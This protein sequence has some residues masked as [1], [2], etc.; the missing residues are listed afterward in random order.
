MKFE[1]IEGIKDDWE[2][3]LKTIIKIITDKYLPGEEYT[4]KP[5]IKEKQEIIEKVVEEH[6][7]IVELKE[8]D[9]KKERIEFP[10]EIIDNQS[11]YTQTKIRNLFKKSELKTILK[12]IFKSDEIIMDHA[13]RELDKMES[14]ASAS[15]YLKKMFLENKVKIHNSSVVLFIDILSEHFKKINE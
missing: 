13:F 1:Q 2:L 4:P 12:K 7:V 8:S 6:P 10:T 3:N 14:W 9:F 5:E 15:E 11:F